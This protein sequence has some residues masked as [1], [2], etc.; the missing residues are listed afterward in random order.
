MVSH[1]LLIAAG[2]LPHLRGDHSIKV[3]WLYS[4]TN[5]AADENEAP[6]TYE[7]HSP[8]KPTHSIFSAYIH[9]TLNQ[10]GNLFYLQLSFYKY[11][12]TY[13]DYYGGMSF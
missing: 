9:N 1:D 3:N 6:E 5:S 10:S 7:G 2:F 12:H 11:C 4:C 8:I 13:Y